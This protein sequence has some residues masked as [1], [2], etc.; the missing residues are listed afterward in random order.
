MI[1]PSFFT[2][3]IKGYLPEPHASLL[4]GIIFGIPVKADK[5]FHQQLKIVGIIHIAVLS[6]S[7]INLLTSIITNITIPLGRKISTIIAIITVITFIL[8]VGVQP[9]IVRAGFMGVVALIGLL[10]GRKTITMYLLLLS[11]IFIAIIWPEW[12]TGI[13]FQLS[14][15]AT[16]GLLIFGKKPPEDNIHKTKNDI[17]SYIKDELRTSLAAQAFTVPIIFLYFREISFISPISNVLI[18]WTIA[19]LMI[20]GFLTAILG[21]IHFIFGLIPSLICYTLL[22]Y[23][24]FLVRILAEIPF[25]SAKF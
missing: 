1:D 16:L 2:D 5:L 9:P 20:F 12:I 25:A 4:N 15:A 8:F 24:I 17:Y 21:K 10:Y 6:G 11:A 3:V 13:S 19:P 18:S 22:S 14:Y 7:N 23:I